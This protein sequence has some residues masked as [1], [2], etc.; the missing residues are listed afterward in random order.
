MVRFQA[1]LKA[2]KQFDLRKK[3]LFALELFAYKI[4]KVYPL[5]EGSPAGVSLIRLRRIKSLHDFMGNI[6]KTQKHKK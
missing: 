3:S 6:I 4:L 5:L 2:A 1:Q